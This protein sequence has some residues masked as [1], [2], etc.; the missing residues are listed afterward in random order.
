MKQK[1][2]YI[3]HKKLNRYVLKTQLTYHGLMLPACIFLILFSYVPMFGIIMAF[4]D[5]TPTDGIFG[6]SFVGFD[7]FVRLFTLD[8]IQQ[9]MFNTLYI[10]IMKII[11]GLLVPIIFALLLNEV[12]NR[13]FVRS[14]QTIVYLPYFLSWV[15]LAGVFIEILS[16]TNGLVNNVM[17]IFGIDPVFFLGDKN[18]FPN[19]IIITDTWKSF[20]FGTIVYLAALTSIDPSL[21]EAAKVDGASYYQQMRHITLPGITNIVVL[22]TVLSIG[23]ILDAGF[24]QIYNLYNPVVYE[25][26]DILDT[27]VYRLGIKDMLFSISTAVSLIKSIVSFVLIVISYRLAYRLTE[28]KIF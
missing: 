25:T 3:P 6:S 11:L 24:D 23:S 7:N 12:R 1:Q 28:Y 26:G 21:Y 2:A 10:S 18:W 13:L 20:G 19:V 15:I 8:N 27:F 14:V 4:Q 22:M 5:F 17:K 16:P 9:V